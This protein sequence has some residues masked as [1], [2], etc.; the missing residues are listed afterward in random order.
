MSLESNQSL[1][2]NNNGAYV[3]TPYFEDYLYNISLVAN[4]VTNAV[5]STVSVSSPNATD[6][7]SVITLSNELKSDLTTLVTD[8]NNSIAQLNTL[9]ANLR[10]S[11]KLNV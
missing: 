3:A 6:L 5:S 8:L 11:G 9:L 10:T 4:A 2:I 7:A 1:I